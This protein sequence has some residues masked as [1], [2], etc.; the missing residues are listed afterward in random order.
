MSSPDLDNESE[1]DYFQLGCGIARLHALYLR[2]Q[3]GSTDKRED[4]DSVARRAERDRDAGTHQDEPICPE[5]EQPRPGDERVE[6]DP[7]MKC[8]FCAYGGENENKG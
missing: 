2:R 1:P 7:P 5:C 3:P 6:S 8:R 4:A